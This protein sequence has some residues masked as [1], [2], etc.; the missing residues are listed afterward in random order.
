MTAVM[1]NMLKFPDARSLFVG[2]LPYREVIVEI[3]P[4]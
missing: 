1:L 3:L 4:V 2:L